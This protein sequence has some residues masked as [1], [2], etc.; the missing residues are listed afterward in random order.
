M[1]Y[2]QIYFW[3]IFFMCKNYILRNIRNCK[4]SVRFQDFTNFRSSQGF[5]S[6][7]SKIQRAEHSFTCSLTFSFAL[8]ECPHFH[9]LHWKARFLWYSALILSSFESQ[10]GKKHAYAWEYQDRISFLTFA[11][12]SLR[13]QLRTRRKMISEEK[14]EASPVMTFRE[15]LSVVENAIKFVKSKPI[16]KSFKNTHCSPNTVLMISKKGTS[17]SIIWLKLPK[18]SKIL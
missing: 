6:H 4:V 8:L 3:K 15:L 13:Y 14:N 11:I 9:N 5:S 16:K 2:V 12:R 7:F 17:G 1:F 18:L 10:N